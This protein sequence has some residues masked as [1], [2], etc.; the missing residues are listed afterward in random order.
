MLSATGE[1]VGAPTVDR[2]D[3]AIDVR[4]LCKSYGETHALKNVSFTVG[5]GEVFGYLG[6]NGAG[7]TTTVNIL[8]G[9]L[10]HD[11]GEV[12]IHGLGINSKPIA[13]KQR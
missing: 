12:R 2:T 3:N 1:E 4:G 11:A 8:C 13:V 10:R 6:P 9:L 5:G 7:K